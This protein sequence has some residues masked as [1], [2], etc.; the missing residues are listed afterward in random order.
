MSVS[1][2]GRPGPGRGERRP[3]G[4]A[5][6]GHPPR[7]LLI[8]GSK[9]EPVLPPRD[10]IDD[11]ACANASGR[12][13]QSLGLP[14]PVFT[15]MTAVLTS[16]NASDEHSLR[17]LRGLR[18]RRLYHLPRPK[19]ERVRG[20][21]AL[22]L[23][24]KQRRMRPAHMRRRLRR[25]DY[26]YEEFVT[27]KASEYHAAVLAL[28]GDDPAIAELMRTKQPSTGLIALAV[29]L[30]DWDYDRYVL[31]GFD[32]QLTH[33]YGTNPLIE[34]RGSAASKHADTD[35]NILCRLADIQGN[36]FT[37]EPAVHAKAGVPLLAELAPAPSAAG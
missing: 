12:S 15:V 21:K 14:D 18:T 28:C 31:A 29:G 16:G 33:A 20:L 23:A 5:M 25:L 8:L 35:V 36:V 22:I 17:A 9:P 19:A 24:W 4:A 34:Q 26:R 30:T 1:G 2:L 3:G 13:A 27:R 6:P 11:V 37:T 32:F 10:S 7:T